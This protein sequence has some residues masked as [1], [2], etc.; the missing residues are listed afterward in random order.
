MFDPASGNGDHTITYTF[1]DVNN[2]TSSDSKTL[3]VYPS[4]TVALTPFS[5]VCN[6]VPPFPLTGGT[7]AGGLYSGTGV[8]PGNIFD[9]S[10]GDGPHTITYT[11]NDANGCTAS[12][13]KILEVNPTPVVAL[14]PFAPVCNS[15]PP[16]LLT[17][18]T[19]IGGDYTGTGVL[20]G[21][22]FDPAS[23]DGPHPITYTV[24]N[25][26]NCSAS[27]IKTLT[28][29]P[30]PVVTF[31]ALP[32]VCIS[33]P[34]Y[35]LNGGA[36]AGGQY[37]GT[38]VDTPTGI[39]SPLLAPAGGQ[40]T[41]TVTNAFN[42]TSFAQQF[43]QVIPMPTSQG[44][45]T[46]DTPVCQ[47]DIGSSYTLLNPDPLATSFTWSLTPAL[48]GTVTGTGPACTV[49]WSPAY[50]GNALLRFQAISGCGASN[51]SPGLTI[52]VKPVPVVT[53]TACNDLKTTKNGKPIVLKGGQPL[54]ITGIY[55]GTGVHESPAGSGRFVFDPDD[56]MVFPMASGNPYTITYRYTNS[57]GCDATAT[58][59]IRV[60][61]SNA[62]Q[63][64]QVSPLSDVRDG[65]SY[66]TFR[67]GSG[68]NQKCWMAKNLN[69]GTAISG[70]T[71]QTDNC[72]FEKYCQDDVFGQCN[73]NGGLYQWN[74]LM[75][76]GAAE[77]DQ[78][79]CPPG[80]H[81]ATKT[82]WDLLITD[83]QDVGQAGSYLKDMATASGFHGLTS[84][85]F[86]LNQTWS[87]SSGTIT[88]SMFWT[89]H[90]V[91]SVTARAN[92]INSFN[93]SVSS[94]NSNTANAFSV[95]CVKD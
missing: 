82:E 73:Q 7:P 46:G 27:D 47:G 29:N 86:Y 11:Y 23:G 28:V 65:Q 49:D 30:T 52:L 26:F 76:Y 4:P 17:G 57:L 39:F 16:F 41:Y 18:G 10:S 90:P 64:C 44:T 60:F 58:E 24:T 48:A 69:Y 70:A 32:P 78:G 62:N 93:P 71:V 55:E 53:L 92:G 50:S 34:P 13:Q 37:S 20:P 67:S 81:V 75:H 74:E 40:I 35:L 77:G 59:E 19:P 51:L 6:S 91:T 85:L 9:P 2:C 80:W 79:L 88:G 95:R 15:V 84:G 89:S 14:A 1:T 21:N 38:G 3:T 8:L 12:D 36:P 87:F 72:T 42:C 25:I 45:Q 68:A 22:I 33:A 63:P 43:Q 66:P 5:A 61:P 31:S 83:N 94:Y 54:G 56:I